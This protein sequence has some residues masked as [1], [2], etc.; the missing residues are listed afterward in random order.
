[1]KNYTTLTGLPIKLTIDKETMSLNGYLPS[2]SNIEYPIAVSMI[3][4]KE[5]GY[6]MEKHVI[7]SRDEYEQLINRYEKERFRFVTIG[8]LNL[9]NIYSYI[10]D[11]NKEVKYIKALSQTYFVE[12]TD[13]LL[14]NGFDTKLFSLNAYK[15]AKKLMDDLKEEIADFMQSIPSKFVPIY[16]DSNDI[17]VKYFEYDILQK[18]LQCHLPLVSEIVYPVEI[19]YTRYDMYGSSVYEQDI[20]YNMKEYIESITG[21]L[22]GPYTLNQIGGCSFGKYRDFLYELKVKLNKMDEIIKSIR[23]NIYIIVS[24]LDDDVFRYTA[25]D[26]LGDKVNDLQYAINRIKNYFPV[27][28]MYTV[29]HKE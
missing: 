3:V 9:D 12:L 19:Y 21:I 17:N 4:K 14:K 7:T 8:N 22:D 5:S 25:E 6:G 11:L 29:H 23:S 20:A 26:I 24:E 2:S 27:T 13:T 18:S 16:T 15:K 10:F 28:I 1:M